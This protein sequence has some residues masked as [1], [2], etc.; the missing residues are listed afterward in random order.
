MV[1]STVG[2]SIASLIGSLSGRAN[3]QQEA[4]LASTILNNQRQQILIDEARRE[5][6]QRDQ[7]QSFG[8]LIRNRGI[9]YNSETG[10]YGI[11]PESLSEPDRFKDV[12]GMIGSDALLKSLNVDTQQ[13][14]G[15][16]PSRMR[17]IDGRFYLFGTNQA[18]E[19]VPYTENATND[20]QDRVLSFSR[21][22]I[23][24]ILGR[25]VSAR[26]SNGAL[27]DTNVAQVLTQDLGTARARSNMGIT[28]GGPLDPN[29]PIVQ[30]LGISEEDLVDGFVADRLVEEANDVSGENPAAARRITNLVL[31]NASGEELR[32]IARDMLGD[33]WLSNTEAEARSRWEAS[34]GG[35]VPD[36]DVSGIGAAPTV[37]IAPSTVPS[38]SMSG[39]TL[40]RIDQQIADFEATLTDPNA[41][42]QDKLRAEVGLEDA[43]RR[44]QQSIGS[45]TSTSLQSQADRNETAATEPSRPTMSNEEA[46]ERILEGRSG[47]MQQ[48]PI[49]PT[50]A[51]TSPVDYPGMS[52]ADLIEAMKAGGLEIAPDGPIT[53]ETATQVVQRGRELGVQSMQDLRNIPREDAR[54]IAIMSALMAPTENRQ[55]VLTS[56]LNFI[57]TG[58]PSFSAGDQATLDAA[59]AKSRM[60]YLAKLAEFAQEKAKLLDAEGQE[61]GGILSDTSVDE[62]Y[63][64]TKRVFNDRLA[65]AKFRDVS[66]RYDRLSL[67]NKRDFAGE[68]FGFISDAIYSDIDTRSQSWWSDIWNI[69]DPD[70]PLTAARAR[71]IFEVEFQPRGNR[72]IT[73]VRLTT[74]SGAPT[75]DWATAQSVAN[76]I[77][78]DVFNQWAITLALL[79]GREVPEALLNQVGS[80]TEE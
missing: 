51:A 5:Q 57:D 45:A 1:Q 21:Q 32:E 62:Q 15:I 74:A 23:D 68:M 33:E 40:G 75:R 4:D 14:E 72:Y 55:T 26:I 20:D 19:E 79:Q 73:K 43:L 77:G 80:T 35:E 22:E 63:V 39:T 42:S 6:R 27:S 64:N 8:N 2:S 30:A 59:N 65:M 17:E 53:P 61:F 69:F 67:E 71:D 50:V 36:V 41:S 56:M 12:V 38:D 44:K 31:N 34:R 58:D 11:L 18:G 10:R 76:K 60:T 47:L 48:D 3:A 7:N 28:S 29:D 49:D 46:R 54:M 24:N 78:P 25:A 9:N 70:A 13:V 52:N 16:S 66:R 37:A